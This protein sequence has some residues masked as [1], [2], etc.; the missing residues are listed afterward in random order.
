LPGEVVAEL[1]AAAAGGQRCNEAPFKTAFSSQLS[2]SRP[3][4]FGQA[5]PLRAHPG[6][7]NTLPDSSIAD[8]GRR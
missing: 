1:D 5:L 4:A 2:G 6:C 3:T 8:L 7:P